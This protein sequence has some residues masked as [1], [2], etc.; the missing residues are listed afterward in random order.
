MKGNLPIL[1]IT[2]DSTTHRII[3]NAVDVL[4]RVGKHGA[5][6]EMC[7]RIVTCEDR[8]MIKNI[9]EEYVNIIP[10]SSDNG[11]RYG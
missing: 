4:D 10:I 7:Y 1:Y 9:L 5:A 2:E 6:K 8:A 3:V 11:E